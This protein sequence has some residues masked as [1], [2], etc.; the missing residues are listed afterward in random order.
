MR[1][2]VISMTATPT[3][4]VPAPPPPQ[5][6]VARWGP[7]RVAAAILTS[8]ALVVGV[9]LLA[10]GT[11]VLVAQS[12]MRDD[13]GYITA[14]TAPWDSPGYAVRS[15][16]LALG[17]GPMSFGMPH[18]MVGTVR[19]TAEPTGDAGVFIGIA[20]SSDVTRYLRG[21]AH[22]TI[23]DPFDTHRSRR[24]FVD[25]GSPRVAPTSATFWAAS[26]GGSGP[27]TI[28]WEPEPGDWTLVV[29][30][31]EGTT[32]VAADVEIGAEMPVLSGLGWVLAAT[33]LVVS[34]LAGTGLWLAV[35]SR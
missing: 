32:P 34:G 15:Q 27:Q 22:S 31:R 17:R 35:R 30:N 1:K 2:V 16:G 12:V 8:L 13:A 4:L 7:G 6:P 25:G 11:M 3:Q 24:T 33:G 26:A 9:G 20:R 10:G 18:R 29:M 23:D 19:V 14:S 21:V 5:V 28:T